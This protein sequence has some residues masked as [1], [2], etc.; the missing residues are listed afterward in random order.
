MRPAWAALAGQNTAMQASHSGCES[1]TEGTHLC[2]HF[3]LRCPSQ[4]IQD[5]VAGGQPA[6]RCDVGAGQQEAAC[7]MC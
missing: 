3:V 6:I 1:K 5:A 2:K 7:D 4:V